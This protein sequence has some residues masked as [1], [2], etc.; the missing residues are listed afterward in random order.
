M[1]PRL[2]T[3]Q[4]INKAKSVH[5][6]EYSY[7]NA[8]Y[9][10]ATHPI[11]I[12]CHKHGD[13]QQKASYHLAGNGCQACS[14]YRARKSMALNT[15]SFI[16]RAEI[17]H[18]D[19]YDYS[20]ATYTN[21]HGKITVICH[22]HGEFNQVANSHLRGHGCNKCVREK[23]GVDARL[24]CEEFIA[25]SKKEH[26]ESYDYR[27]VDYIGRHK[28]V[29]IICK[30]HGKFT[31]TPNNHINGQ[32]CPDCS[33]SGFKISKDGHL[34]ILKSSCG[35]FIKVGISNIVEKRIRQLKLRTPFELS[36]VSLHY[37]DGLYVSRIEKQAHKR[38]KSA[39]FNGFDGATEW[40][41][42]DADAIKWIESLF[43][44]S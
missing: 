3:E 34:Y 39:G 41:Y 23:V 28:K 8:I 35:R 9:Q 17:V 24:S 20:K 1:P 2:T 5:G 26:G 11:T 10:H 43:T 33:V 15:K 25:N 6:E 38:M 30:E 22:R 16:S 29:V 37:S 18:G 36:V 32:G 7:H 31:Q 44:N 40:F 42:F 19:K 21:M 14:R 13:F 4:F 12:T 27:N